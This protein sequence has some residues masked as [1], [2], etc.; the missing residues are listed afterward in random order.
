MSLNDVEPNNPCGFTYFETVIWLRTLTEME[1]WPHS[2]KGLPPRP[3]LDLLNWGCA[4]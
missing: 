3:Q 1:A 4:A 2:V